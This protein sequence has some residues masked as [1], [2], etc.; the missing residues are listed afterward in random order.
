M[1]MEPYLPEDQ[2]FLRGFDE[3]G[4][5]ET[6]GKITQLAKLQADA[7]LRTRKTMVELDKVNA[8]LSNVALFF[9]VVQF[10]CAG[11]ALVLQIES[12][13]NR[14]FSYFM[15]ATFIVIL[16]WFSRKFNSIVSSK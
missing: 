5:A 1:N 13:P 12:N 11:I 7:M 9:S 16:I 10:V 14:P 6:P 2:E 8:K 4:P 15:G 3:I